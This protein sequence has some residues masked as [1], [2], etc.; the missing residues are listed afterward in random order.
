MG[1]EGLNDDWKLTI[2]YAF[3]SFSYIDLPLK[4]VCFSL[5]YLL[6]DFI[7][8]WHHE[9]EDFGYIP[10]FRIAPT[11]DF[12]STRQILI[13]W[14]AKG[15]RAKKI[16]I[17][18]PQNSLNQITLNIIQKIMSS[19]NSRVCSQSTLIESRKSSGNS[20]NAHRCGWELSE[21]TPF[22]RRVI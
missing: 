16:P 17:P 14:Y 9:K 21:L 11:T 15:F 19:V 7:C 3:F 22:R 18:S 20:G 13:L 12:V 2:H 8:P 6:G 4:M 1:I 5:I 10:Y